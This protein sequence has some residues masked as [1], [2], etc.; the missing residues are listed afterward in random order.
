MCV[1]TPVLSVDWFIVFLKNGI[2]APNT[3]SGSTLHIKLKE[4]HEVTKKPTEMSD[5][6]PI[7]AAPEG[8]VDRILVDDLE[9]PSEEAKTD[10]LDEHLESFGSDTVD[11][12]RT[13]ECRGGGGGCHAY[14]TRVLRMYVRYRLFV[15]K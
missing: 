10:W 4:H 9:I 11:A 5:E 1:F 14:N 13:E 15:Y 3:K 6:E 2:D 8:G 7:P 12:I